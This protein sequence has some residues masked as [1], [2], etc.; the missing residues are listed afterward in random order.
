MSHKDNLL[1]P[2]WD[3]VL[4]PV[5]PNPPATDKEVSDSRHDQG[6]KERAR[7]EFWSDEDE[8]RHRKRETIRGLW[9]RVNGTLLLK[10][11]QEVRLNS[12]GKI[13]GVR[14]D[15]IRWRGSSRRSRM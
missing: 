11:P 4:S 15:K 13:K 1:R 10:R 5:D 7:D 8:E 6:E 14:A 3:A 12:H 9:T 2:F